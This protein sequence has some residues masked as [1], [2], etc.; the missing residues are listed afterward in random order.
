MS[1]E[2]S[3]NL[4]NNMAPHHHSPRRQEQIETEPEQCGKTFGHYCYEGGDSQENAQFNLIYQQAQM[5]GMTGH[6]TFALGKG[7]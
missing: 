6:D 4:A 2:A 3:A 5:G 7:R 1:Q